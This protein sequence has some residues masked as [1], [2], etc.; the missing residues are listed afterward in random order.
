MADISAFATGTPIEEILLLS[1]TFTASAAT[2]TAGQVVCINATGVSNTVEASVAASGSQPVGVAI[3]NA[4]A[5][6]P[7]TVCMIG[8][9]NVV[10]ADDTTGIDAGDLL[11][12]NDNAVKGTVVASLA[13]GTQATPQ[14]VIGIALEDIA[15]GSYGKAFICPSSLTA[16]A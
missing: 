14:Q 5:S 16:H 9:C 6:G 15:G 13:V 8:V 1:R 12:C 7:V 3:T 10:N 11:V 2:I 4:V